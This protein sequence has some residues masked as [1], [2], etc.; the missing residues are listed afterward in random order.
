MDRAGRL[1]VILIDTNLLLLL[2]V[3]SSDR[4]MIAKHKRMRAYDR[5]DFDRLRAFVE[6]FDAI[7]TTPHIL[8]EVA[9]L[10]GQCGEPARGRIMR[11]LAET[12]AVLEERH[13]E[14]KEIAATPEFSRLGL[15]DVGI[16]LVAGSELL[17][18]TDDQP[19]STHLAMIGVNYVNFNHLRG[20]PT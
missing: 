1:R 18:L 19:L 15:T 6:A 11:V 5:G 17:V 7:V 14:S 10:V 3:G 8:T 16:G 4:G 13:L 12:I 9:N 2:C 20:N